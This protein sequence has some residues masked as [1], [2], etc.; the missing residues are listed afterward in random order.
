M[1][2]YPTRHA[3][4]RRPP[5]PKHLQQGAFSGVRDHP[6]PS[7]GTTNKAETLQNVY[8]L[9][10][11]V[12]GGVL[13]RPG[14][15]SLATSLAGRGQRAFSWTKLDGTRLTV[16][17]AG[18]TF[19]QVNWAARTVTAHP[20]GGTLTL[21]TTARVG[22]V[23]LN[24]GLVLSDGVNRPI[25]ATYAA[26][27]WTFTEMTNC[28]VLYGQP[29]IHY[30]RL[31][32]IKAAERNTIVWS[33]VDDPFTGYE[34]GGYN[35]AWSLTQ[36]DQDPL[37]AIFSTNTALFYW[38]EEAIGSIYGQ[39][40]EEWVT[41]GV[42]DD[43]ST[44]IGTRSPWAVVQYED[45]LFFPDSDGRMQR[46]LIGGDLQ[47]PPPW[48][49]SRTTLQLID[50]AQLEDVV[51]AAWIHGTL[52][53]FAYTT[54][55]GTEPSLIM[56]F[57]GVTGMFSGTWVSDASNFRSLDEVEGVDNRPTLLHINDSGAAFDWGRPQDA[58]WDDAG[59]AI[60]HLVYGTALGWEVAGNKH[61]D[62]LDLSLRTYT[63]LTDLRVGYATNR[64]R[65]DDR[66]VT[67]D[68]G[69]DQWD[70]AYWDDFIWADDVDEAHLPIG[71]SGEGR[72]IVVRVRHAGLGEQFGLIGWTVTYFPLGMVPTAP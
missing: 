57:N 56:A 58:I 29:R 3:H 17:I 45:A 6:D 24:D 25:F 60:E 1:Y 16:M 42:Q 12:G 13:G 52:V 5:R 9:D 38:R 2:G 55:L 64:A 30:S 35:N 14:F 20:L 23:V 44:A 43:I 48:L 7:T 59:M 15:R 49:D 68:G 11:E 18:G 50:R 41:T 61:Y 8:P 34:A 4:R 32:G 69:G 26:G 63:A 22:I 51:G 46:L 39:I 71:L 40:D 21:S 72:W 28:P 53:L 70:E 31:V 47:E 62:R 65:A 19:Y 10:P 33:E 36:T 37:Y 66:I 67:L 27:V 54:A